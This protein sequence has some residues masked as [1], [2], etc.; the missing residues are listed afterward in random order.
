[1]SSKQPSGAD[2]AP[3]KGTE[4]LSPPRG[5]RIA[6]V[7]LCIVGLGVAFELTRIHLWV[8][9]DPSYRSFCALSETVNCDTVAESPYSVFLG[10]PVSVWGILGYLLMGALAASGLRRRG[11]WPA[12]VL[13]G[14][15]SFSVGA[16]LLLGSISFLTIKSI[17]L[18]CLSTYAVNAALL[19][20]A[21]VDQRA[22]GS[23][24]SALRADL[25]KLR[26]SPLVAAVVMGLPAVVAVALMLTYP[27]YWKE[28]DLQKTSGEARGMSPEG[29]AWI[30]AVQPAVTVEEYSDYECPHCR[31]GHRE[32]RRLVSRY[33]DKLRFVHRHFPLDDHC[34]PMITRPFHPRACELARLVVCAGRQQKAWEASDL[35]FFDS[36]DLA[37][38]SPASLA[39]QLG[40]DGAALQ[41]CMQDPSSMQ[42]VRADIDQG[43]KLGIQGTPTYVI[44]DHTYP[45]QVPPSVLRQALGIPEDEAL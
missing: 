23:L 8:H 37:T 35:L 14:L 24:R 29:H 3:A 44:G 4:P 1:V 6:F 34:N 13:L 40:I 21:I 10:V 41:Q 38:L 22:A 36:A 25:D 26:R 7:L 11:T 16:S 31:R 43:R 33:P 17:C 5:V 12:G 45:G 15:A 28:H 32:M 20:L 2:G 30:G 9:A 27:A 18:L 19:V 39:R 42:A